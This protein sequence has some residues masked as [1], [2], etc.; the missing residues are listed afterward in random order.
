M[1]HNEQQHAAQHHLVARQVRAQQLHTLCVISPSL[2]PHAQACPLCIVQQQ[3]RSFIILMLVRCN[4]RSNNWQLMAA[5]HQPQ[6]T[7][8][9][10]WL[11]AVPQYTIIL[12]NPCL[13]SLALQGSITLVTSRCCRPTP[14]HPLVPHPP[15]LPWA[16]CTSWLLTPPLQLSCNSMAGACRCCQRCRLVSVTIVQQCTSLLFLPLHCLAKKPAVLVVIDSL[17]IAWWTDASL[18]EAW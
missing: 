8:L 15:Q 9:T 1:K 18:T 17:S 13:W 4:A 11:F 6:A 10:L 16:Y 3:R 14:L 7:P 12:L 2:P 5:C